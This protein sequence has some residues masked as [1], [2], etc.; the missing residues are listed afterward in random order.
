M[1]FVELS[2]EEYGKIKDAVVKE[3]GQTKADDFF[4]NDLS[5][6]TEGTIILV[7]GE[8]IEAKGFKDQVKT[9]VDFIKGV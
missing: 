2:D 4:Y 5:Y 7:N 3:V 8:F 6:L 1:N 9:I